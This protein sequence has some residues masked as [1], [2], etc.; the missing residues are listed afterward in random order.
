M[1][2]ATAGSTASDAARVLEGQAI[3]YFG[4]DWSAENRTSSHHIARRLS[5]HCPLLYVEVPGMRPPQA[6]GRAFA[7]CGANSSRRFSRRGASASRCGASP[8]RNCRFA[9][10][11][12][13]GR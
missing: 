3:V 12:Y 8:C 10:G 2:M 11:Q 1:T 7:N 6:T 4:N 13:Y 9:A 5:T